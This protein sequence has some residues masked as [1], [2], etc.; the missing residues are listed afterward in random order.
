MGWLIAFGLAI[1]VLVYRARAKASERHR[2]QGRERKSRAVDLY[3][4]RL[5]IQR[6]ADEG[7]IGK[8]RARDLLKRIDRAAAH[9]LAIET[10]YFGEDSPSQ[11]TRLMVAWRTL[12]DIDGGP[13]ED[14]PWAPRAQRAPS[15]DLPERIPK[16][17]PPPAPKPG[18]AV[19]AQTHPAEP[20]TPQRGEPGIGP[21]AASPP[22]PTPAAASVPSVKAAAEAP[23]PGAS[24]KLS[25]VHET[26][27]G[28][29]AAAAVGTAK[30][31]S[32]EPDGEV[33]DR[34]APGE[35]FRHAWLPKPP[36]SL[37]RALRTLAGWPKALLPFLLQ[38]I[39]WFIGAFCFVTGS[40]FLVA[41]TTGFSQSL[42]IFFS[43]L[44]YT[45]F[46][47]WA[48]YR[49]RVKRRELRAASAVL[50]TIGILL[51]PL[52]LST[53]TRILV[54]AG[55]NGWLLLMGIALTLGALAIFHFAAQL[56]S[57]V[58]DRALQGEHPRL[59]L[60]L[61]ALQLEVPLLVRWPTW[62]LLALG[63]GLILSILGYGVWRYSRQW[64]QSIFVEQRKIAYF[65]G[66]TL[67]FAA[68]ISFVHL[69]W[70]AAPLRV[71]VGY[72][73]PYLMAV[74]GMLFYL[75]A[76]LKEKAHRRV[77][78][79][80]LNF[81]IYGLSVV[82]V[83]LSFE[84][85]AARLL[86][87]ILAA[88]I[89]TVVTWHYLTVIPL[90][91]LVA[92]LAGLYDVLVLDQFSREW[93]LLLSLPG[94]LG[95]RGAS[96]RIQAMGIGR[97]GARRLSLMGFR[98]YM[99][100]L[101]GCAGWS[102]LLS[103]RGLLA[104]GTAVVLAVVLWW[105]L[106][107][108]PGPLLPRQGEQRLDAAYS[109]GE[110]DLNN[111]PGL[112]AVTLALTIAWWLTPPL[113]G[114]HWEQQFAL[115]LLV[116]A[117]P[118]T[119]LALRARHRPRQSQAGR[120][121]ALVNSALLAGAIGLVYGLGVYL[122]AGSTAGGFLALLFSAAAGMLLVLS[123]GLYSR[124]LFYICLLAAGAAAVLAKLTLLPGPS[125]G[126][127]PLLA[128]IAAWLLLRRLE[129]QPDELVRLRRERAI[130]GPPARLLWLF[131]LTAGRDLKGEQ[132][133]P[134]GPRARPTGADDEGGSHA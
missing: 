38:N 80:R 118:W 105:S 26:R 94:L 41:Y 40:I 54:E 100:L 116:L 66:G 63:H 103:E 88:A 45:L 124:G 112:Y 2:Y 109:D 28:A 97:P 20:A 65:A 127:A 23:A 125:V 55:G 72:Y 12:A 51:V 101:L 78:L 11:R 115:G 50:L 58:T 31:A 39:G 113:P 104:M 93:M 86:T 3:I 10:P 89:Y 130:Q 18:A 9:V 52:N 19:Q 49:L 82:A 76:Q 32:G 57:G 56:V 44:S 73:G 30:G 17:P 4:L 74:C 79:S 21:E 33:A 47:I 16:P 71:P 61:A 126:I 37:E 95:L 121:E 36:D 84:A 7:T 22:A 134:A 35:A 123:M 81:L 110:L 34:Q 53:A 42:I 13:L 129:R 85:P 25:K 1:L 87:L 91:L 68:L 128:G 131:P 62:P 106:R 64:M 24:A 99:L 102:L 59:F 117:W 98:A 92:S 108:A 15:L 5:K 132:P 133:E 119:W 90:Y 70:G 27:A 60:L 75:D 46:L 122:T 43:V 29:A 77:F 67:L 48:G 6:M 14:P 69:T 8:G 83:L 96:R 114:I 111:G 120:V 107:T